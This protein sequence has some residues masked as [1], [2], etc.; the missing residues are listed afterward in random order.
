MENV[1]IKFI[2]E[3]K[4]HDQ[5]EL[6]K[7]YWKLAKKTHPDS[8]GSD[9]YVKKF[10]RFK[11][12]FEEAKEFLNSSGF[13]QADKKKEEDENYRF[14]FFLEMQKLYGLE[15][16]FF[17]DDGKKEKIRIAREAS[18]DFFKKWKNESLDLYLSAINE[19][20]RTKNEKQRN[21]ISNLRKPTIFQNLRP[22]F[23]NLYKYHITGME[24]YKRQ[25]SNPKGVILRLDE[26]GCPALKEYILLLISDMD[27][28]P[29]IFG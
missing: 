7:A 3:G 6:K 20:D 14:L 29:A 12:H 11:E 1:F 25:L 10:I 26:S 5:E 15:S 18:L 19:Y 17:I 2:K 21:I 9:I 8:V 24:F 22:V 4:I 23:Y 27:N 16:Q 13:I 28:G